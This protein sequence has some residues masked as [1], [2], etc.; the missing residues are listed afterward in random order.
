M[1]AETWSAVAA[2]GSCATALILLYHGHADRRERRTERHLADVRPRLEW[3]GDGSG[4]AFLTV[5]NHGPGH[6]EGLTMKI[7][8]P[9]RVPDGASPEWIPERG[10]ETGHIG[11]V[12]A[13]YTIQFRVGWP[14]T[15]KSERIGALLVDI[16][17]REQSGA[18]RSLHTDVRV[19]PRA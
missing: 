5:H 10:D 13:G 7:A 19:S 15:G 4:H 17:W 2:I 12:P 16:Q 1:P 6:A 18:R 14:E 3:V 9:K 11:M 8:R